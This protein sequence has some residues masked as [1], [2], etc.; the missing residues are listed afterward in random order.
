M[1]QHDKSGNGSDISSLWDKLDDAKEKLAQLKDSP[2]SS[3]AASKRQTASKISKSRSNSKYPSTKQIS[4]RDKHSRDKYSK[5]DDHHRGVFQSDRYQDKYNSSPNSSINDMIVQ[6][7]NINQ[8]INQQITY[9]N[10]QMNNHTN[11]HSNHQP[12]RPNKQTQ[13]SHKIQ[14]VAMSSETA[15]TSENGFEYAPDQIL[16]SKIRQTNCPMSSNGLISSNEHQLEKLKKR[17][18]AQRQYK[19]QQHNQMKSSSEI[20]SVNYA[21]E[22]PFR[23]QSYPEI[24]M[25]S[26][27]QKSSHKSNKI[28]RSMKSNRKT[29]VLKSDPVLVDE[30]HKQEH[31]LLNNRRNNREYVEKSFEKTEV[32]TKPEKSLKSSRLSKQD[33]EP[34]REST[35]K[36][37][38]LITV[39][40]MIPKR[41]GQSVILHASHHS[42]EEMLKA[43]I[44]AQRALEV[45]NEANFSNL[46]ENIQE[47]QK[48]L[49]KPQDSLAKPV[50]KTRR[51][52]PSESIVPTP[53]AGVYDSTTDI[54]PQTTSSSKYTQEQVQSYMRKQKSKRFQSKRQEQTD[55]NKI[56]QARQQ[57]LKKLSTK[58]RSLVEKSVKTAKM[59]Q[60][61]QPVPEIN[62]QAGDN[63]PQHFDNQ[64]K[65]D[66]YDIEMQDIEFAVKNVPRQ[67]ER[68]KQLMSQFYGSQSISNATKEDLNL[69][70][71]S[72]ISRK[73]KNHSILAVNT[74]APGPRTVNLNASHKS[75][76]TPEIDEYVKN[77]RQSPPEYQGQV[78]DGQEFGQD[79]QN[80]EYDRNT[81]FNQNGGGFDQYF[82]ESL[83]D[84]QN[85][86]HN[87]QNQ[88]LH[89]AQHQDLPG[90]VLLTEEGYNTFQN[91]QLIIPS[92]Q[93]Q[94]AMQQLDELNENSE[95]QVENGE[96]FLPN[97]QQERIQNYINQ[98]G[99]KLGNLTNGDN[100]EEQQNL[101]LQR[102][103]KLKNKNLETEQI[104]EQEVGLN[105]FGDADFDADSQFLS[106]EYPPENYDFY[107][108]NYDYKNEA[109][110][111]G[112][113]PNAG[114]QQ[115]ELE[116]NQLN[117]INQELRERTKASR[118]RLEK[119][120]APWSVKNGDP[121]S[122]VNILHRKLQVKSKSNKKTSTVKKNSDRNAVNSVE[123]QKI[124]QNK[125][126][127]NSENN[128]IESAKK[129][130][131]QKT[132]TQSDSEFKPSRSQ[133]PNS[134]FQPKIHRPKTVEPSGPAPSRIQTNGFNTPQNQS[135]SEA[136]TST[137][138]STLTSME[139]T[140]TAASSTV[141]TTTNDTLTRLSPRTLQLKFSSA[142]QQNEANEAAVNQL[143]ELRYMDGLAGAQRETAAVASQ[144][145]EKAR[146]IQS[147]NEAS[148]ASQMHAM[149]RPPLISPRFKAA[150]LAAHGD[151]C[152]IL[153]FFF[154]F[155]CFA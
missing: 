66:L 36:T 125:A 111:G 142:V 16:V 139:A 40:D 109:E 58:T 135:S 143:Q 74:G 77:H 6:T 3:S 32:V 25:E 8:Q 140:S 52:L 43:K 71:E 9:Q 134:N 114:Q 119:Q 101:E 57:A 78:L 41:V 65:S 91:R 141:N 56:Q 128:K 138:V 39:P 48:E 106:P 30:S 105:K 1:S 95:N 136:I 13:P 130:M 92:Q 150:T 110:N 4:T 68:A 127:K 122:V 47:L 104:Y 49:L 81:N 15:M 93:M 33:R 107:P 29:A 151:D 113:P 149:N 84:A 94:A 61:S 115:F 42:E 7:Q 144:Q 37:G 137:A 154:I 86:Q 28:I 90:S 126:S 5:N 117:K 145:I 53:S 123:N 38:K 44:E 152:E 34:P 83:Q 19:Q 88:D 148:Y 31:T 96:I 24:A 46:P 73:S 51:P 82:S 2:K 14:G 112:P 64:P 69:S 87:A 12:H 131:S 146:R 59:K 11:H 62:N 100:L 147:I 63:Q 18:E 118:T 99:N 70:F 97:E 89:L 17:I 124:M 21:H 103:Q 45:H 35:R 129:T 55:K 116:S 27:Q 153:D 85:L 108:E 26:I 60:I 102:I 50:S 75:E 120:K 20:S 10:Q 155:M 79:F 132:V 76:N 72:L 133:L 67:T 54:L 80:P 121:N 23:T 22:E 98:L